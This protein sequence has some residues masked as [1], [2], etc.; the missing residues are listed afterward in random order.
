MDVDPLDLLVEQPTAPASAKSTL[1]KTWRA[2]L[3]QQLFWFLFSSFPTLIL[4]ADTDAP[5]P[6]PNL[7]PDPHWNGTR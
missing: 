6:Q 5:L 3:G 7:E 2:R 1:P 4:Y